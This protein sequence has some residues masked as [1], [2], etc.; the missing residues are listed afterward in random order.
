MPRPSSPPT[1][2]DPA[3]RAARMRGYLLR[4]IALVVALDAVAIALF[5]GLDIRNASSTVRSTFVVVWTVLT[6]VLV[7]SYLRR[8]RL[9]RRGYDVR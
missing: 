5:Y 8:I 4:M 7:S 6:L 1:P 2:T 9:V 3:T